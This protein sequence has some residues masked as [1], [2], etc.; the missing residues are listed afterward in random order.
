MEPLTTVAIAV[1]TLLATKALEK[2]GYS[3][4][5]T[6][7]LQE[8]AADKGLSPHIIEPKKGDGNGSLGDRL[9]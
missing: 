1:A 8:E 5:F 2:I 6:L 7:D 4:N 3:N 9:S